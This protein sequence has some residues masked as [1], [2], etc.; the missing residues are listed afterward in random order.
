MKWLT[1][2]F[3]VGILSVL[4]FA[5]LTWRPAMAQ[6]KVTNDLAQVKWEYQIIETQSPR[7]QIDINR[8]E[9]TLNRLGRDGWECVSTI[10]EVTS[11]RDQGT[12]TRGVLICKR[13]RK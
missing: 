13:A 5:S 7:G 2:S 10:S 8:T 3:V 4:L 12:S 9:E 1:M 11:S 6:N